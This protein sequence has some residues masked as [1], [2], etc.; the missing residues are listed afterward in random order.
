MTAVL[1]TS[2]VSIT[3]SEGMALLGAKGGFSTLQ[4][5]EGW[6]RS[7][8]SEYQA[9]AKRTRASLRAWLEQE[10]AKRPFPALEKMLQAR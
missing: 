9:A 5:P 8:P 7:L 4:I 6:R 10:V 2:R 1:G 3:K